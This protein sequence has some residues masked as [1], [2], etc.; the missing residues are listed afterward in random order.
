MNALPNLALP[1]LPCACANLRRTARAVTRMYN[2]ELRRTGL[3]LT[4]FTLLMTLSIVGETTQGQL[5]NLLALD[6]TSLTRMLK[7]LTRRGWIRVKA[8]QDRRQKLLQLSTSGRAKFD[9]SRQ[10]WERAQKRLQQT[11]S[12]PSWRQM[13]TLLTEITRRI[14]QSQ[15]ASKD[16]KT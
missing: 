8:G 9:E 16:R 15:P 2:Y 1:I 4:Q 7:P 12:E 14:E 3:E 5:G 6:S 11:L 13:G 10:D